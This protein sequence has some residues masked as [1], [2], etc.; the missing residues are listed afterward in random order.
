[1]V[2]KTKQV[3]VNI[4]LLLAGIF[5]SSCANQ[6]P[7]GGG[8]VDKIPPEI[9]EVYPQDGTTNFTDN[10]FEL[11]FSEYVDKRTVKD[12]I[13]ISPAID[14]SLDISWSGRYVEVRFPSALKGNTT[15]VITLGTDVVDHNN[16]NRMAQS[17][18]FTFSTGDKIDRRIISGKVY[19]EK[20]EGIMMFAYKLDKDTIDPSIIKPDYVSQCGND[21]SYKLLGLAAS[22]Y[23]IFAV[24]DE[25]RDLLYNVEQDK[26]GVPPY[27]VTLN[28]DDSLYTGLDFF[29]SKKDTTSPRMLNAAMTDKYHILLNL[30]EDYDSS[31]IA[32]TNFSVIDSTLNK[33]IDPRY[34]YRHTKKSTEI[35]LVI[36]DSLNLNSDYFLIAKRLKDLSGNIYGNDIVSLTVSDKADTT[37]PGIVKTVP[38]IRSTN[39]DY[40]G[41]EFLFNF[42]DAFDSSL[43]KSGITFSDTLGK[44]VAFK[45][46]FPDDATILIKPEKDLEVQKDY[47]IK[48]DLN[49]AADVSG[50]KYDS[51]YVFRF[52]TI[53][54]LEFTGVTGFVE[55]DDTTQSLMLV[56]QDIAKKDVVYKQTVNRNF[57]FERV[58]AGKYVMW[59]HSTS[60]SIKYNYG[61]VYPYKPADWFR[62]HPDT[63]TLKPRWSL[64]DF[65]FDAKKKK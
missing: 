18:S 32:V 58:E 27:D 26:I 50:N 36:D 57:N 55:S 44:R 59:A 64:L 34:I 7:P 61:E 19:D 21:G 29:L 5:I 49:K 37:K 17:F 16:R 54:G 4:F 60:D 65:V 8:E 56:L 10:Y 47:E 3:T 6:L 43:L 23:R 52:K 39:V 1:M 40:T 33:I 25:F 42:S 13:F 9:I 41:S 46:N 51:V 30:S 12:A 24:K 63:L 62:F 45:I 22:T 15:Y 35:V 48:I 28:E 31:V 38:Q 2:K 11:G 20:P 14:G 53:S